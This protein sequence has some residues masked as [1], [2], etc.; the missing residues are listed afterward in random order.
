MQADVEDGRLLSG[1][2]IVHIGLPAKQWWDD[3]FFT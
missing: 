2:G 3:P 1:S